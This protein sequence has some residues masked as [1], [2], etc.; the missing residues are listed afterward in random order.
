[1]QFQQFEFP[2]AF[3]IKLQKQ[4][5]IP[6]LKW[7]REIINNVPIS[8]MPSLNWKI[9]TKKYENVFR[10][11]INSLSCICRRISKYHS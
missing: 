4:I 10:L 5:V 2:L 9:T 1:M 8:Q 3:K 7:F 11:N 6:F